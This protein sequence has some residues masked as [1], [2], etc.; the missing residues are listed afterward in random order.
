MQVGNFFFVV[1]L[2]RCANFEETLAIAQIGVTNTA[3]VTDDFVS[4]IHFIFIATW[5]LI[6]GAGTDICRSSREI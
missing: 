3:I 1:R 5:V 2:F 6:G 4:N